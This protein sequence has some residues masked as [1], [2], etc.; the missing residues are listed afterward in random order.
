VLSGDGVTTR[1]Y[2]DSPPDFAPCSNLP[3][4]L[5]SQIFKYLS[6]EQCA[7]TTSVCRK[8]RNVAHSDSRLWSTFSTSSSQS[9]EQR[10]GLARSSTLSFDARYPF[11]T[12]A[13]LRLIAAQLYRTRRLNIWEAY[14]SVCFLLNPNNL[15]P[16]L[17]ILELAQRDEGS[18]QLGK[19][20]LLPANI[21]RTV[22][23]NLCE[24][25]LRGFE[26]PWAVFLPN[27]LSLSISTA[28]PWTT[29]FEDVMRSLQRMPKLRNLSLS[30]LPTASPALAATD[31]ISLP[32]LVTLSLG[33]KPCGCFYLWGQ[34][35]SRPSVTSIDTKDGPT[36]NALDAIL[37]MSRDL[38]ESRASSLPL[39][40]IEVSTSQRSIQ[41]I[42]SRHDSR[43]ALPSLINSEGPY[44]AL[45]IW[46]D[47]GSARNTTHDA[48]LSALLQCETM[49]LGRMRGFSF[50]S[51]PAFDDNSRWASLIT[52]MPS[53]ESLQF[54]G[55][56]AT[57]VISLCALMVPFTGTVSIPQS[58]T[59][60][61]AEPEESII[62]N[63]PS[64]VHLSFKHVDLSFAQT[65]LFHALQL[66]ANARHRLQKLTIDDF[67][68]YQPYEEFFASLETV[69]DTVEIWDEWRECAVPDV[70]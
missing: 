34:I 8:W 33:G 3:A 30:G 1:A 14:E 11:P 59:S 10:L 65:M 17:R 53:L 16:E 5:L 55:V 31:M 18:R 28:N 43:P 13:Q 19:P 64:L 15:A 23:P 68:R 66:R 42:F 47:R 67:K 63:V 44:C 70:K 32:A 57:A 49:P 7:I 25:S 41:I 20:R 56:L 60:A 39:T 40:R 45:R 58:Q 38:N 36:F 35:Q 46:T 61:D 48:I 69:V 50:R 54:E 12:Q 29:N 9:W 22:A 51:L 52:F 4:E 62:L 27:L 6:P 26:Y 2:S 24:I 21:F 37:S